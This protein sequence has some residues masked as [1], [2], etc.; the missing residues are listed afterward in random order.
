MAKVLLGM[1]GGID[2]SVALK[3][4]IE[5][6][7]EVTGLTMD[8]FNRGA[9]FGT[10]SDD[11]F[12]EDVKT[13]KAVAD[14]FGIRHIVVEFRAAFK[15]DV[16]NPFIVTYLDG[17]TPNPCVFCNKTI[18]FGKL[19][20]FALDRGFEYVATGHYAQTVRDE[21]TGRIL[22]KKSNDEK[23]DQTYFL[24]GLS[25]RQLSHSLFPLGDKNKEEVRKT[26]AALG[27]S[28]ADKKDSQ[29]ICFVKDE[30]YGEFIEKFSDRRIP[31][32]NFISKDG[33][34]LGEHKGIVNYTIGQRKGL[35]IALG[36]PLFVLE[37]NT[38]DNTIV[39]GDN[40]DLMSKELVVKNLNW[41]ISEELKESVHVGC[42]TRSTQN[43]K[44]ASV[45]PLASN[46]ARV[47]FK[48]P[49]RAFAS[50][51]SAVFYIG[52]IVAG[53]GVITDRHF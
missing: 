46:S 34:V 48:E 4:L 50:G 10:G 15:H 36:K 1:S 47:V 32:G 13:A 11:K 26:A 52:D 43:C 53:G 18:K 28:N 29:D 44:N 9:I 37:K 19:L 17:E 51:Q 25:Q 49:Q 30:K 38:R 33:A 23:K 35:G 21:Q 7:H 16:I 40:D 20:D 45:T 42:K 31:Y 39:L 2:S 5:Q 22:L 6:G 8:L 14:E 27:F 41:I 24:Y 12:D 3:I